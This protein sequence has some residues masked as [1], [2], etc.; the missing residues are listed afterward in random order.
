MFWWTVGNLGYH[1]TFAPDSMGPSVFLSQT[2]MAVFIN[3]VVVVNI[4]LSFHVPNL[5]KDRSTSWIWVLR[6]SPFPPP[7]TS[8][9]PLGGVFFLCSK[10]WMDRILLRTRVIRPSVFCQFAKSSTP[11]PVVI[12][13]R[14]KLGALHI[15]SHCKS[16]LLISRK[17][18]GSAVNISVDL[19][20]KLLL[21]EE[22]GR[23]VYGG[24]QRRPQA[25]SQP[26]LFSEKKKRRHSR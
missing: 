14:N 23:S 20:C 7:H 8:F 13:L 15:S 25:R 12:M 3:S 19:Q 26:F 18:P 21:C 2:A 16:T 10:M 4:S 5:V 6:I 11:N 24:Y 9:L 1:S 17:Q 22:C